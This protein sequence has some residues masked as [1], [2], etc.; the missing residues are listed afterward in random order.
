MKEKPILFK[1]LMVQAILDGQKTQTRRPITK[2]RSGPCGSALKKDLNWDVIYPNNPLGIKVP[3]KDEV[4]VH[5]VY[6]LCEKGSHLWVK[7]AYKPILKDVRDSGSYA[8]MA[9][10]LDYYVYKADKL[11]HIAKLIKW[12]PSIFMPREAS[13]ITLEVLDIRVERLQD[14]TEEDAKAEGV[15]HGWQ[16]NAGWPDYLHIKNRIC[17]LTQDTAA[18]SFGTL[19][20]SIN[21]KGSWD[22]NPWVWVITFKRTKS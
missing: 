21:G 8:R 1:T 10:V 11:P 15:G 18:M 19:W 20:E 9:T 14:I 6:P 3:H 22:Q 5:R 12:K 7:E 13:R 17:S 2:H 4:T 16:M